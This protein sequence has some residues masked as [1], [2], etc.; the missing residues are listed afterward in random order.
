ML[1]VAPKGKNIGF[2][3]NDVQKPPR[4]SSIELLRIF[5]AFAVIVL[6][7][8][9]GVG[10]AL[11]FSSGLSREI[12][13]GLESLCV[14][15]VDVFI[16]ISGYFLCKTGKRTWDK[17]VYLIL[18]MWIIGSMSYLGMCF[19]NNGIEFGVDF[20][21]LLQKAF[22][23]VNYFVV[24]Y[25]A[26][27]IISPFIN[28]VL[29]KLSEKGRTIMIVVMLLLFSLYPTMMDSYQ[30]LMDHNYMGIDPVGAWGQQHGYTIV[31][32]SLCYCI[33][34][35]IRLNSIS[36]NLTKAKVIALIIACVF[37]IYVWYNIESH[38]VLAGLHE[39]ID[40]NSFS[41]SN[42]LVLLLAA[43]LLVLF[44]NIHFKSY[45]INTFSKAAFVSYI[46]HPIILHHLQ[47]DVYAWTGG[48]KLFLHL[49]IS[50]LI[51]YFFS[52]VLWKAL[53]FILNPIVKRLSDKAIYKVYEIESA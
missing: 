26:L 50:V 22:P 4:E 30:L 20:R 29:N 53:D 48:W 28:I 21:I 51:I 6:H 13:L 15:A 36:K 44:S 12:L 23:P 41:Y 31:C 17:P 7:Y 16:M 2:H 14:C 24:L 40:Y 19:A 46:F 25:I 37:G 27:Y 33:G 18:L 42:P 11:H 34:A 5:A 49:V 8:N 45:I 10:N 38:T 52:W 9:G 1:T 39:L 32:F 47:V 43:L 3:R 35:W